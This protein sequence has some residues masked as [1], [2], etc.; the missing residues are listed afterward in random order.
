M[1]KSIEQ[2]EKE[3]DELGV[4]LQTYRDFLESAPANN[5]V[6]EVPLNLEQLEILIDLVAER[7]G[8]I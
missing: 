6:V 2:L 5:S 7:S 1:N 4:K 3:N 8:N